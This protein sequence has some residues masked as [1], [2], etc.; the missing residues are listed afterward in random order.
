[1]S[2]YDDSSEEMDEELSLTNM[3]NNINRENNL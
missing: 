1:M 2:E 3:G